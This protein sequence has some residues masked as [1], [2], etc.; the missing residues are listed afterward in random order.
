MK[1]IAQLHLKNFKAFR[2]QVFEFGGKNVLIYGNNGSGKSSL[3]WA[4][5]TFLQSSSKSN[6]EIQKY[7][8]HFDSTNSS[9]FESLKNVFA[10]AADDAFVKM[11]WVDPTDD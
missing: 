9:T 7:F 1:K 8:R 4:I 3:F 6:A 5:Y 2:D 10:D 11:K